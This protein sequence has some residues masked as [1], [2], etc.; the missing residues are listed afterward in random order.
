MSS[1]PQRVY[2][3]RRLMLLVVVVAL[4]Y[5]A[6]RM[7]PGSDPAGA[8]SQDPR[9][10]ADT[11]SPVSAP[12]GEREHPRAGGLGAGHRHRAGDR[13]QPTGPRAVEKRSG[14]PTTPPPAVPDGECAPSDIALTPSVAD[15]YRAGDSPD[16]RLLL[17]TTGR[18]ACVFQPT[19]ANLVVEVTDADG[20]VWTTDD[21]HAAIAPS[22]LVVRAA[23]QTVY[24]VAWSGLR[25][26][27]WCGNGARL[28]PAGAYQV[29][30]AVLG[31]EPSQSQF[32]LAEPPPRH[33][34]HHH[35]Q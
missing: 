24:H 9:A 4:A 5:V 23:Q 2:W 18:P 11:T 3:F 25:S 34:H 27:R 6:S 12:G 21:C 20:P 28:A 15:T 17:Q 19:P 16:I 14:K 10:T 7:L 35:Q 32:S 13:Q 33:R 26:N 29:L 31:G 30:A 1:V 22:T 8:A